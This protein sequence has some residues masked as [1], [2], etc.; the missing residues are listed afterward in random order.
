MKKS[1]WFL[2]VVLVG[3]GGRAQSSSSAAAGSAAA[4]SKGDKGWGSKITGFSFRMIDEKHPEEWN[5]LS[6]SLRKDNFEEW[7][8][9]RKGKER[10]QLL[11]REGKDGL[12]EL[13]CL[14]SGKEGSG[15]YLSLAGRFTAEDKEHIKVSFQKGDYDQEISHHEQN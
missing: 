6:R 7:F 15:L 8:S 13:A 2:L 11:S 4:A 5:G 9:V 1:L 14:I 3:F 12:T 10:I